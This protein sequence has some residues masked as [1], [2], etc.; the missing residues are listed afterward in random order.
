M[1]GVLTSDIQRTIAEQLGMVPSASF[2]VRS[3]GRRIRISYETASG[4]LTEDA[5]ISMRMAVRAEVKTDRHD[6]I[7]HR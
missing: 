5:R 4:G 7:I 3:Q 6:T 2:V 1:S